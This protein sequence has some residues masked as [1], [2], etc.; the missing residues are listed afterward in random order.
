ML[1]QGLWIHLQRHF[2]QRNDA[3]LIKNSD[4]TDTIC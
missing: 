4:C 1:L 3:L 2:Q